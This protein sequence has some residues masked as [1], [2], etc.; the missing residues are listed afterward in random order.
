M[1]TEIRPLPEFEYYAPQ[2]L[3]EAIL[4]LEQNSPWAKLIAGGTDLLPLMKKRMI[5]PRVLIDLSRIKELSFIDRKGSYLHIGAMTNL[6]EILGSEIVKEKA[7]IL[8]EA[9]SQLACSGIRNRATIGGN[10]CN[11]SPAA[12]TAP[13]LLVLNASVRLTGPSGERSVPL[14]EFFLGPGQTTLKPDEIMTEVIIPCKDGKSV[15]L[16]LGRRRGFTLSIVSAAVFAEINQG[17]FERISIAI[18]AAAPTPLRCYATESALEGKTVNPENIERASLVVRNEVNPIDDVR[19]S[20]AYRTEMASV[21]V[22]RALL[23]I[24]KEA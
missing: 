23:K 10:L 5:L 13:P 24:A 3:E 2:S 7:P 15:F 21:L 11:A 9:I 16:K 1:N 17:R 20:A 18:G 6:N 12:D 4:L 14:T 22:K 19:A 8:T